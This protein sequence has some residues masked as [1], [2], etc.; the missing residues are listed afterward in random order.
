MGRIT[1]PQI[2]LVRFKGTLIKSAVVA[3]FIGRKAHIALVVIKGSRIAF[4]DAA[5][6]AD[7]RTAFSITPVGVITTVPWCVPVCTWAESPRTMMPPTSYY[8]R[9]K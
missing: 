1:E 3:I 4:D 2:I 6:G 5:T 8:L 7:T 9:K